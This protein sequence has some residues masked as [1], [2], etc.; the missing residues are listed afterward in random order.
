MAVGGGYSVIRQDCGNE[1]GVK[2]AMN[3]K[4]DIK[5]VHTKRR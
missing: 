5:K 1:A 2:T 4:W 3:V